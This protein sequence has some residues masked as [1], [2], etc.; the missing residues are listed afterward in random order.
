MTAFNLGVSGGAECWRLHRESNWGGLGVIYTVDECR[1]GSVDVGKSRPGA[2]QRPLKRCGDL[3]TQAASGGHKPQMP[4][5]IGGSSASTLCEEHRDRLAI[6]I[7]KVRCA[8][9][10]V[11]LQEGQEGGRRW[12]TK[13]QTLRGTWKRGGSTAQALFDL[14]RCAHSVLSSGCIPPK[15]HYVRLLR[16]PDLSLKPLGASLAL[17]L[18]IT[19]DLREA[20]FSPQKPIRVSVALE[21]KK[22][23]TADIDNGYLP[24]L[25]LSNLEIM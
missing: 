20:F 23:T 18:A 15:M 9:A 14:T 19:T 25:C 1:G 3:R 8:P 12:M 21:T 16:P 5:G 13:R 24:Y 22:P 7:V 6:P 2:R 4:H 11:T 17:V 10:S